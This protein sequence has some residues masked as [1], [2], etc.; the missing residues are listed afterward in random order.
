MSVTPAL[1]RLHRVFIVGTFVLIVAALTCSSCVAQVASGNSSTPAVKTPPTSKEHH[2][3]GKLTSPKPDPFAAWTE[4]LNKYPGLLPE[5][6]H[7]SERIRQNIKF[8]APRAESKLLSVVPASTTVYVAAPNYGEV[9]RQ[10]RDIVN[11][12][13]KQSDVLHDWWTH[14][15]AA[16]V[17][18]KFMDGLDKISQFDQYLGD[19][20]AFS[21]TFDPEHP[22][23]TSFLFVAEIRKPGLDALLRSAAPALGDSASVPL[24]VFDSKQLAVAKESPAGQ[25]QLFVLLRCDFVVASSDLATLRSYDVYL[26]SAKHDFASSPFGAHVAKEYGSG[27]T[28]LAAAD[29]QPLLREARVRFGTKE[30]QN[31]LEQSGFADVQYAILKR[32][33]LA[34]KLVGQGELSFTGPRHGTA[35]WLAKPGPLGSLDFL[36]PDAFFA[37]AINLTGFSQIFEDSQ[38]LAGTA[39][40][41]VF[42]GIAGGAQAVNLKL[43]DDLLDLL[44][45]EIA[46]EVDPKA[47]AQSD[48]AQPDLTQPVWRVV[49]KVRDE[50]HLQKTFNTLLTTTHFPVQQTEHAD[51][52]FNTLQ[53][54][55]KKP[56]EVDYAISGGY[57]VVGPSMDVLSDAF[58]L[59]GS[60]DSLATSPKYLAS[61]PAGQ[62][63]DASAI[64]Y[65]NPKLT[66]NG[67]LKSLPAPFADYLAKY[68]ADAPP[69]ITRLYGESSAIREVG[70]SGTFDAGAVLIGAAVAI[71][72]LLRSKIAANEASAVGS[73]RSVNSA[74]LTYSILFAKTGYAPDLASLG[75]DPKNPHVPSA[76]RAGLITDSLLTNASCTG[77]I[78]CTKSGYNF[79]LSTTCLHAPCR[80]YVMVATPADSNTGTRSFCSTSDGVI[81]QKVGKPDGVSVP[82]AECRTWDPLK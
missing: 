46:I 14:G 63:A 42:A 10:I 54:P 38:K 53:I 64:F 70:S 25:Q 78:P 62:S 20:T 65:Q 4:E 7:L 6:A 74:Q 52:T 2:V 73:L 82:V 32:G 26:T 51:V 39:N 66:L 27:A 47:S 80:E 17:G 23:K 77:K 61:L 34:G 43:K 1:Q 21:Y 5:L 72:N 9:I 81:R 75:P 60:P 12:E 69:S 48:S 28:V 44:P 57:L 45:G 59:H 40:A 24:R 56:T 35:A 50:Q 31:Y 76:T 79:T 58:H 30:T 13:L 71:P 3:T 18:P 36:S 33:L 37:M 49:L 55:G 29:L 41:N 19:E 15:K 67:M 22:K 8:P 11:D 68:A 16:T